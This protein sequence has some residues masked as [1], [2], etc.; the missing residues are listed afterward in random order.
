MALYVPRHVLSSTEKS[1]L[2]TLSQTDWVSQYQP[3]VQSDLCKQALTLEE[4]TEKKTVCYL[5]TKSQLLLLYL[6]EILIFL[7]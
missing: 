7:C 4:H 5:N 6:M 1:G 2:L 3:E